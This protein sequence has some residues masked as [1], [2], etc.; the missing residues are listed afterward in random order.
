MPNTG[1]IISVPFGTVKL[2]SGTLK[3]S[4]ATRNSSGT[5]GYFLLNLFWLVHGVDLN[6]LLVSKIFQYLKASSMQHSKYFSS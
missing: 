5:I 4:F 6:D 3:S 1:I 2:V